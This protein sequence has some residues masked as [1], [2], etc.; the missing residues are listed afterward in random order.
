MHK[1]EKCVGGISEKV[2]RPN[3]NKQIESMETCATSKDKR[4]CKKKIRDSIISKHR[5]DFY[6][7]FSLCTLKMAK[8]C[9]FCIKR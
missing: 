2:R 8:V 5:Q 1:A 4:I 6:T 7:S 9:N 3:Y